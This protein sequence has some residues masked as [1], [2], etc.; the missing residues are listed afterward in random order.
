ME[1]NIEFNNNNNN[2]KHATIIID[3][4]D[5]SNDDIANQIIT[6]QITTNQIT[7]NQITTN[8]ITTNQ[9]INRGT[10][11][12][13]ANTNHNGKEFEEKTNNQQRLLD[14]GYVKYTFKKAKEGYISKKYED[15]TVTFAS[16]NGFKKYMKH[17]FNIDAVN[18]CRCPDEA[19]IIEY[20]TG[21]KVIKILEKKNQN[22]SGS[23]ETKLWASPSLKREYEILLG[24]DFEVYYG[25]CV[26]EYLKNKF[27]SNKPIYVTLNTILNESNI[28]VLFGDDDNYF[29][30]LTTWINSF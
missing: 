19:Y 29:E 10:G 11:A 9:S 3:Y 15:K 30:T 24:N 17:Q 6:N 12:G 7:T 20:N 16:Q 4:G 1:L 5:E 13:G 22:R 2:N 25:L 27:T 14:D 21:R 23:V 8:Q 26:N 18:L 28:T